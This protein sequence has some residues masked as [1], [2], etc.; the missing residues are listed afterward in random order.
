MRFKDRTA[1]VTGG[2]SGIGKEVAS[3]F[4]AEGGSVVI[5]GRDAAKAEAAARQID[6][7]GK[8]VAAHAGD[9]ALP[10]TSQAAV[11]KAIDRFGR[12]DVL[13][14]MPASSGRSRFLRSTKASMTASSI[15]SSRANSSPRRPLRRL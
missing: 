3:R 12:L 4:V 5:T 11:A 15:S 7:T 9:I 14:T 13:L 1:V 8:Y 10:A 2:S 6:P